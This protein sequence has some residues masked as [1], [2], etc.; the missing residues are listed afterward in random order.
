M[1]VQGFLDAVR[2]ALG[3]IDA[4]VGPV[5]RLLFIGTVIVAAFSFV[6][7]SALPSLTDLWNW[8]DS[9]VANI[10]PTFQSPSPITRLLLSIIAGLLAGSTVMFGKLAELQSKRIEIVRAISYCVSY[11]LAYYDDVFSTWSDG[12]LSE[13]ERTSAISALSR[14]HLIFLCSRIS[15]IFEI[16]TGC[17]CHTS[18]KTF[19][20]ATGIVTTRTRDALMHNA[21]RVLADEHLISYSY[22][23]N[24]AFYLI[25]TDARCNMYLSNHLK[26]KNMLGYYKNANKDWTKYYQATVV[27]PI[28]KNRHAEE[29]NRET[30]LGFVCVDNNCGRLHSRYSSAILGIF[31]IFINNMLVKLGEM[32]AT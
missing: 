5:Y 23:D 11:H 6:I 26:I 16:I 21:D 10:G 3:T 25:L 30:V 24:T 8:I 12:S 4:Y 20:S 9:R 14:E 19:N 29:L 13:A 27:L 22:E 17:K 15:E 1:A 7:Y 31:V 28:S 2:R 32:N 18:I